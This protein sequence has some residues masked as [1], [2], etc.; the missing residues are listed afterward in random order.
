[1]ARFFNIFLDMHDSIYS[2]RPGFIHITCMHFKDAEHFI[3]INCIKIM[4]SGNIVLAL[5]TYHSMAYPPGTSDC[6][7]CN[8]EKAAGTDLTFVSR[9]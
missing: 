6:S 2:S 8:L 3:C 9:Q 7:A 1:M 4:S 5:F